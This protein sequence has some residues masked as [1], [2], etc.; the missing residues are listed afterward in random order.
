V[1]SESKLCVMVYKTNKFVAN[2][3]DLLSNFM[4]PRAGRTRMARSSTGAESGWEVLGGG[5]GGRSR[6]SE[7]TYQFTAFNLEP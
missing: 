5:G 1:N 3:G 4:V 2:C 6:L 7:L